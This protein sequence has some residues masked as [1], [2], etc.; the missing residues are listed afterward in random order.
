MEAK[1]GFEPTFTALQTVAFFPSA[2]SPRGKHCSSQGIKGPYSA[3]LRSYQAE[4]YERLI[5]KTQTPGI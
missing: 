1:V 4:S 2:T 5:S 3:L